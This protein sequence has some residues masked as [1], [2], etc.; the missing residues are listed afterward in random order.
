MG[1]PTR[2]RRAHSS[3]TTKAFGGA[4][5]WGHEAFEECAEISSAGACGRCL[6]GIRW[7]SLWGPRNV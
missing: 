5:L 4:P 2:V 3:V 6:L 7:S 1:V